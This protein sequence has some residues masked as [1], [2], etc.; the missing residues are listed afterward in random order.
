MTEIKSESKIDLFGDEESTRWTFWRF[1]V[2]QLRKYPELNDCHLPNLIHNF[3][4]IMTDEQIIESDDMTRVSRISID[5]KNIK[6]AI[7]KGGNICLYIFEKY[8]IHADM[9]FRYACKYGQTDL[10]HLLINHYDVSRWNNGLIIACDKGY[11]EIVKLILSRGHADELNLG[12]F[13]AGINKHED[14]VDLLISHGA[15]YQSLFLPHICN[16][17]ELNCLLNE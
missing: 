16:G 6:M 1:V 5:N 17:N 12:L 8:P 3:E 7:K 9:Y 14:I 13:H 15:C 4:H 2:V 11:T 10:V